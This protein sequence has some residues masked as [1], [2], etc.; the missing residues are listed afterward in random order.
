MHN[1]LGNFY[2]GGDLNFNRIVPG[3]IRSIIRGQQPII[4]S[5]GTLIRDYFYIEDAVEA[6]LLLA[7][8]LLE[9]SSLKGEA[10]NFSNNEPLAVYEIVDEIMKLMDLRLLP[11]MKN[12]ASNEITEQYLDSMKAMKVLDWQP[13]YTI[14]QGLKRTIEW[15]KEF[16]N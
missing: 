16:F 10:F 8:K 11:I 3:T 4:R 9:D 13:Q 2:G 6:Y 5:D 1:S 15:Y 12:E 7:E 14:E